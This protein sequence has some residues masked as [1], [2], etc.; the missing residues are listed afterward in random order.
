MSIEFPPVE[1]PVHVRE[2]RAEVRDFIARECG[3]ISAVKR[4]NSWARFDAEFSRKLGERGW[5]GM[6]FPKR[7]G[8]HERSPLVRYAVV[9][10]L[11]AAGAPVAAHWISDRQSA[12]NILHHGTEAMKEKWLPQLLRGTAYCVIGM[13][14]PN[15]G[16]DLASVRTRAARV[17]GGWRINGQKI[18]TTQAHRSH[19]MIALVRTE[20]E[21][22]DRHRGLSQFLIELDRPGIRIRP[23][24]DLLGETHFNEVFLDDVF[25]PDEALL[26]SEGDG[27]KLV[28][29]ELALERSGPERYLS[30]Y[31]LFVELLRVVGLEPDA[32]MAAL[33]GRIAAQIWTLRLMSLS[34]AGALS[35]GQEASTQAV[36]VKDLGNSFEQD[37][38]RWIQAAA[39]AG[40]ALEDDNEF[41][42][43]LAYLL[44][45]SPSFSL[46]GGTRE[47]LRGLI[48]RDLGLR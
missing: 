31:A 3:P 8:G 17:E 33:I 4:A 32:S 45:A 7:Y 20:G 27:W 25:V 24:A 18:W 16:S 48:A 10:E 43:V 41:A 38:P 11:L 35:R 26:G 22:T 1:V 40:V 9:E 37:L 19:L 6:T 2:V 15:T 47:I 12:H 23:I 44:Q 29:S 34:V 5:I 42:A 46:R 13:S 28:N 21:A 39:D 30:S 14:E 36:I